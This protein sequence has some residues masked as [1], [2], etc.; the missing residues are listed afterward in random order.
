MAARIAMIAITTSSSMSVNAEGATRAGLPAPDFDILFI[1]FV[2]RGFASSFYIGTSIIYA[3]G[4][5]L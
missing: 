1:K 3:L 2:S 4:F 5:N